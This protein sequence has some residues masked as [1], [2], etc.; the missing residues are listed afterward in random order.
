M[1][2]L[3]QQSVHELGVRR[4]KA[5]VDALQGRMPEFPVNPPVLLHSRIK[6][7]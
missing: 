3:F 5:T 6:L 2:F 1:G 4:A 7:S